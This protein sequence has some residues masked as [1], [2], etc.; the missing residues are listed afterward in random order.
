[1]KLDFSDWV[2]KSLVAA[3]VIVATLFGFWVAVGVQWCLG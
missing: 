3:V 1:M 2:V